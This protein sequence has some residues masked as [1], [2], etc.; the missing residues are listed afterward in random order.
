MPWGKR[1]QESE[2]ER[3]IRKL[4]LLLLVPVVIF[5]LC[6]YYPPLRA[7]VLGWLTAIK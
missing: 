1:V 2:E 6:V 4:T 5:A 3:Q 7:T